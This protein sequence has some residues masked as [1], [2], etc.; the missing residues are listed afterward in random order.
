M[1]KPK[2]GRQGDCDA[3]GHADY[4]GAFQWYQVSWKAQFPPSLPQLRG[5]SH[6]PCVPYLCGH[7]MHSF[8]I[9]LA[10]ALALDKV[11]P[12]GRIGV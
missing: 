5:Y 4:Y 1:W 12:I 10:L 11:S 7:L 8:H 6:V 2:R 9:V 3:R